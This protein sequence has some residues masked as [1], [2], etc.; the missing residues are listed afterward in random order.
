MPC[1]AQ[2]FVS[3][4]YETTNTA[5]VDAHVASMVSNPTNGVTAAQ[6][7]ALG[8]NLMATN[9]VPVPSA[10]S[11]VTATNGTWTGNLAVYGDTTGY[12]PWPN[13]E[14]YWDNFQRAN[15]ILPAGLTPAPSISPI[16]GTNYTY[17]AEPAYAGGTNGSYI[18]NGYVA[19]VDRAG[20]SNVW[21]TYPTVALG[22]KP[23]YFGGRY[24]YYNTGIAGAANYP[25]ITLIS[26]PN[27]NHITAGSLHISCYPTLGCGV[28]FWNSAGLSNI[29]VDYFT[30]PDFQPPLPGQDF[31]FEVA[32]RGNTAVINYNNSYFQVT[33]ERLQLFGGNYLTF[34][35]YDNGGS[36]APVYQ[37]QQT[38]GFATHNPADFPTNTFT[39]V[40]NMTNS[41][42]QFGGTFTG[43]ATGLTNLNGANLQANTVNSNSFDA[44]TRA[45]LW[46]GTGVGGGATNI[47][48]PTNDATWFVRKTDYA[49]AFGTFTT[50]SYGAL[51]WKGSVTSNDFSGAL[52]YGQL[53]G[54]PAWLTTVSSNNLSGHLNYGQLDGVPSFVLMGSSTNSG[55]IYF[56]GNVFASA[57]IHGTAFVGDIS[58]GTGLTAAQ[59]AA[60]AGGAY[61]TTNGATTLGYVP[62][63]TGTSGAY[64]WQAPSASG[65]TAFN[66]LPQAGTN[67]MLATRSPNKFYSKGGLSATSTTGGWGNMSG[68][69]SIGGTFATIGST[70]TDSI[71]LRGLSSGGYAALNLVTAL[72]CPTNRE[73][74]FRC[75]MAVTNSLSATNISKMCIFNTTF[76]G[77]GDANVRCG[78]R[79]TTQ[80]TVGTNWIAEYYNGSSFVQLTT[81]A[82]TCDV[83]HELG[84]AGDGTK[85]VWYMDGVSV[86]TNAT[87]ANLGYTGGGIL[88]GVRSAANLAGFVL[89]D[90]EL[91]YEEY[92][93]TTTQQ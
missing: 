8:Q 81:N 25:S 48:T 13:R 36:A 67:S 26:S 50:N 40:F 51:A 24:R 16:T 70:A 76:E 72:F 93:S 2:A 49:A 71:R 22:F 41:T 58:G 38:Y 3:N 42:N 66:Y 77:A 53:T 57:A 63:A 27:S 68:L 21:A 59:V 19:V 32:I 20:V 85:I 23:T 73:F 60:A 12:P 10:T 1:M 84:I 80:N 62:T 15:T 69:N 43:N 78:W 89:R 46:A 74:S 82:A 35:I 39:E 5:A 34:E 86:A 18:T 7:I 47:F 44:A 54:L 75:M 79:A 88:M 64:T 6:A 83:M 55:D 30:P 31:P 4:F 37:I 11:A 91:I 9:P 45:G 52:N 61:V 65:S 56:G 92:S 17:F 90:A 33:D 28:G 87:P 14:L 29:L